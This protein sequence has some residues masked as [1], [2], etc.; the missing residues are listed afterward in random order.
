VNVEVIKRSLRVDWVLRLAVALEFAGHGWLV[1]NG[2]PAWV[3]FVTYW[4]IPLNDAAL[5]MRC[6]GLL[7]FVLAAHV[8][9]R[10]FPPALLWMTFWGLFTALMRPLTG[11]PF[12][13]FVE[14]GPNW[15]APLALWLVLRH[16]PKRRAR[17]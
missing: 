16:E 11:E 15:G 17:A 10:P 8:L 5:V 1:F 14:R 7:D 3:P 4:G 2:K 12:V 6:V 9:V 13:E